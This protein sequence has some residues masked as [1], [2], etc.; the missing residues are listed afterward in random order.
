MGLWRMSGPGGEG[1]YRLG[2]LASGGGTNLQAILDR[3]ISG[4]LPAVVSVV[5]SNNSRSGALERARRAGVPALHMSGVTHGDGLGAA[6]RGVLQDHGVELVALA[7]YMKKLGPEVLNA[8]PDRILNTHPAL[9]PEFGGKGMYGR[10]VHEAVIRC[11]ARESGVTVHLVDEVYDHGPVV[12][13]EAVPV[14]PSDTPDTLAA[15]VL[16]VEHRLYPRTI[17]LFAEG[18]VKV[19]GRRVTILQ[20]SG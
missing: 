18:R 1:A 15:R 20:S 6:L 13:Q 8:F 2:V 3:S 7:G 9:L 12:T 11:R 5:V 10:R 16:E 19:V 4:L 14:F 17:G